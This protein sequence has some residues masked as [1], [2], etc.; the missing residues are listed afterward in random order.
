MSFISY[1]LQA[2][3]ESTDGWSKCIVQK[4]NGKFGER[5]GLNK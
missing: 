3:W 1:L 4:N 5:I 2:N